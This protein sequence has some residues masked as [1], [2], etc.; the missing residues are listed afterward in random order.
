[1]KAKRG[2]ILTALLLLVMLVLVTGCNK[3]IFD[4]TYSYDYAYCDY[5]NDKVPTEMQIKK[6]NDYDG[7]QL[8]IIDEDGN[9]WLVNS[10]RCVLVDK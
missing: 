2:H 3:Q 6:W 1:M 5:Q 8:Q 10:T 7:E 9:V 4:T